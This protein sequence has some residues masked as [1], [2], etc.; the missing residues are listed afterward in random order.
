[1]VRPPSG[2]HVGAAMSDATRPVEAHGNQELRERLFSRYRAP[3]LKFFA[4]RTAHAGDAEDL[5][6]DVLHR[7]LQRDDLDGVDKIDAFIFATAR[8]LLRDRARRTEVRH[9]NQ[10]DLETLASGVEVLSPERVIQG[11][12]DLAA[13]MAALEELDP[14]PRDMF[15]LHRLDGMKQREI[16]EAYG[17]SVSSVEKYLKTAFRHVMKSIDI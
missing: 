8:N 6:H 5:A 15:I 4:R 7:M 17:L 13:V 14:K 11:R 9:R 3:L 1:M 12:Q 2:R 10:A 16:A